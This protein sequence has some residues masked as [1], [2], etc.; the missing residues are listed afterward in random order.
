MLKIHPGF[1]AIAILLGPAALIITYHNISSYFSPPT[2][3]NLELVKELQKV[4]HDC[5][6]LPKLQRSVRC[7]EYMNYL[8]GCVRSKYTCSLSSSYKL[9]VKLDFSPP[10]L[11]LP[12]IDTIA[13]TEATDN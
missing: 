1:K 13:V 7:D 10:P 9:L 5:S 6:R 11:R 3:Y 12:P 4:Y 2:P 8:D